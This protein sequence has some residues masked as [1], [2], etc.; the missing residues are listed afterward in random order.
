MRSRQWE[1]STATGDVVADLARHG[2]AYVLLEE[3]PGE[4]DVARAA[5]LGAQN[6]LNQR[7]DLV[8]VGETARGA[9]W[10]VDGTIAER[11]VDDAS[12]PHSIRVALLQLG[13]IVVAL[14]L[15]VPTRASLRAGRRH[16]RIIGEGVRL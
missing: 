8:S 3:A 11:T 6:L 16:P 2:I 1:V 13:V 10:S 14:L 5:R 7:A 12:G 15:A 4:S 9:L